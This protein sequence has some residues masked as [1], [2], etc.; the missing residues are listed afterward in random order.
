MDIGVLHEVL[1][2][3]ATEELSGLCDTEIHELAIG[4]GQ[5]RNR[6]DGV[7][8]AALGV[9]DQRGIWSD[10]G[11]KSAA[12]RF[13][14]EVN[15]SKHTAAVAVHRARALRHLPAT[16]S[17]VSSGALSAEF[18]DIIDK[19]SKVP[20]TVPFEICEPAILEG[21]VE[22]G[23]RE[24]RDAINR[25]IDRS[26]P[27]GAEARARDLL[28]QRGIG[29][30]E[31]IDGVVHLNGILPRVGGHEWLNELNRLENILYR[32]DKASGTIRTARQRRA[33]A[34]VEMAHRSADTQA[35]QPARVSLSV[36]LGLNTFEHLCEL[37]EGTPLAPGELVPVLHRA[38]VER[39]VFDSPDRVLTV[40]RQRAFPAAIR[41]ALLLR[42]RRC[43][44]PSGCDTPAPWCDTDHRTEHHKGGLTSEA[45][46]RLLCE[47]HNRNHDLR[48]LAPALGTPRTKPPPRG[49]IPNTPN[50]HGD[51]DSD[52][53]GDGDSE[54]NEVPER[55]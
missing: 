18:I 17:A 6:I 32:H 13:A 54:E 22:V 28:N 41:R 48:D 19:A 30:A 15:W 37:A 11:S 55:S 5:A 38:D 2:G 8:L 12:A 23:Y 42:D 4:L 25:W 9:W 44:H 26:D 10:D 46:G 51:S 52:G 33:D 34:L 29:A 14:R 40:S 47:T 36:V 39:I 1:D 43:T 49:W 27:D 21:C 50:L 7:L 35:G 3:V 31:T 20:L 16:A 53:D 45:N 24:A